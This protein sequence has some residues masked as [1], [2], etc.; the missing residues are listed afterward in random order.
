M[1]SITDSLK[2]CSFLWKVSAKW[3]PWQSLPSGRFHRP[4]NRKTIR[5]IAHLERRRFMSAS[6]GKNAK[7]LF[8]RRPFCPAVSLKPP[9]APLLSARC[10]S[11]FLT[12][13]HLEMWRGGDSSSSS[14]SSSISSA[15]AASISIVDRDKGDK[16]VYFLVNPSLSA[17]K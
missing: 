2:L 17:K 4:R 12:N 9:L 13:F 16:A 11:V 10:W 1:I 3:Y 7:Q 5:T 15:H 6:E 14:S 8:R